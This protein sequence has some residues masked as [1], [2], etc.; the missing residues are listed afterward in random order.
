MSICMMAGIATAQSG[1]TVTGVVKDVNGKPVADASVVV[2]GTTIGTTTDSKGMFTL[3][4]V[5]ASAKILVVSSINFETTDVSIGNGVVSVTLKASED[6][7]GEVVVTVPYGTVKRT[8]FTGSSNTVS[9][10]TINKQQVTS[11]SR[12]LEGLIPGLQATNGGGAPG[13]GAAVRL[14][15]IGSVNA[16]S[17]PLYVVNGVP[18]DGSISAI[19]SEDIESIDVLKDAAAANLYGSRA[20]NGV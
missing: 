19:A 7:L 6:D 8:A 3:T 20:A 11:V 9:A 2:K 15:G 17:S 14:R 10:S 12:V 5:P 4:S 13:S 16:S 18:Y 1:R